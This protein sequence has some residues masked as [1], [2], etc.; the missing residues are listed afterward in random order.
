M[1]RA[2]ILCLSFAASVVAAAVAVS[3]LP[4]AQAAFPGTNGRVVYE[5]VLSSGFYTVDPGAGG[6][7]HILAGEG[8]RTDDPAYSPDGRLIA[9][10]RNRDLW[11]ANADGTAPRRVT[12]GGNNDQGAAFSPDGAS[13]VFYRVASTDLFVVGLDGTGLRNL[14]NDQDAFESEPAWSPDGTTIAYGRGTSAGEGAVYT[15]RADGTNRAIITPEQ[16]PPPTCS[17]DHR[18][19]SREPSWSPDGARIAFT[20]V[21]LCDPSGTR[22]YGTDIWVMRPDGTGKVNITD[23]D[24]VSEHEPH[25]SPDG[26]K[27]AFLSDRD[28]R[29]GPS[30]LYVMDADGTDFRKVIDREI[31]G[32]DIDWGTGSAQMGPPRGPELGKAVRVARVSGR[33]F[34][35]VPPR[36]ARA[37]GAVQGVKGRRFVP[38]TAARLVPVGALLDT[39]RGTV[40]VVSARNLAGAT[41]RGTFKSGVFQVLQSRRVRAKGLTELRLKGASFRSCRSAGPST[42]P[43]GGA[44]AAAGRSIRRL[45]GSAQGRFR[46]RGRHSAATVRGTVWGVIDRCDGTLTKVG[47]G[48]VAVRD[49]R[50]RKTIVITAGRS[51]LAKARPI[52]AAAR[53]GRR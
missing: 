20:G 30:D 19:G 50:R 29:E 41:Q 8:T 43:R 53:E 25:W 27:I 21:S 15:I 16:E 37:S 17:P 14:T 13:L 10:S 46:T 26:T 47:R 39:R 23:N 33:V 34:V 52:A 45:R 24:G 28:E 31:K 2:V 44:H 9:Y 49:F 42:L 22:K 38:L 40:R 48:N 1:T 36:G 32:E 12:T 3:G 11:V 5:D 35:A 6:R 18:S 51:Y 7:E 4:G